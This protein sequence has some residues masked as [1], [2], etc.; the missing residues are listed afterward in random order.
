MIVTSKNDL[1]HFPQEMSTVEVKIDI[2]PIFKWHAAIPNVI[3]LWTEKF[4]FC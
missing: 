2:S 3:F 1:C 4:V